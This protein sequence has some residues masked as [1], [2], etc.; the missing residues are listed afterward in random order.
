MYHVTRLHTVMYIESSNKHVAYSRAGT[1]DCAY[2]TSM[3]AQA[4][5]ARSLRWIASLIN[6]VPFA[7]DTLP[8]LASTTRSRFLAP[9]PPQFVN[10]QLLFVHSIASNA[11][12]ISPAL[13]KRNEDK[14]AKLLCSIYYLE[15]RE[16]IENFQKPENEIITRS[17]RD[18]R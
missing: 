9:L 4:A 6:R 3:K 18:H 15:F 13:Y 2:V 8:R 10:L 7:V 16:P 14:P 12:T 11:Y 17:L 1:S 5:L